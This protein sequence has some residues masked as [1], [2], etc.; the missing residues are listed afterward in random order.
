MKNRWRHRA[1]NIRVSAI[2]K[3]IMMI[4][5]LFPV[6]GNDYDHGTVET[7]QGKLPY[8]EFTP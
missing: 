5:A 1:N 6:N 8:F 2:L 3:A 4:S 7:T